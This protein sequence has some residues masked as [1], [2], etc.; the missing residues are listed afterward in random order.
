M[1]DVTYISNWSS[2]VHVSFV[3]RAHARLGL[4]PA[5]HMRTD[6]RYA[7]QLTLWCWQVIPVEAQR[8]I[9]DA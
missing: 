8:I 6:S 9:T 2:L 5:T 4:P 1:A 3:L 7:Q